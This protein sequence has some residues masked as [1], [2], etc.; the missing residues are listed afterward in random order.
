MCEEGGAFGLGELWPKLEEVVLA[1]SYELL[2][3]VVVRHLVD[4]CEDVG[5]SRGRRENKGVE[6]VVGG[7]CWRAI[8]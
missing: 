6:G 5:S 4:R 3:E 8:T 2:V 7:S 1:G